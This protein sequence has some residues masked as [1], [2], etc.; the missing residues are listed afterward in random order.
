MGSSFGTLLRSQPSVN[1]MRFY[2]RCLD[3]IPPQIP[4]SMKKINRN[5]IEEGGTVQS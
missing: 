5:L 1:H 4:I 3:E 2:W